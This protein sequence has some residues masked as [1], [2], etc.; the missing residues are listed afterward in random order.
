MGRTARVA[1]DTSFEAQFCRVYTAAYRR[2]RSHEE[3]RRVTEIVLVALLSYEPEGPK[4]DE[5][6]ATRLTRRA[7]RL[8]R[9]ET[10]RRARLLAK[11][12][13]DRSLLEGDRE[14]V[15]RAVSAWFGSLR[16]RR[17]RAPPLAT[18]QA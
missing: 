9:A 7:Y 5:D 15:L 8:T 4:A 14:G 12:V 17:R 2:L 11:A 3:A 6:D 16:A 10:D 1:F 18:P 13:R